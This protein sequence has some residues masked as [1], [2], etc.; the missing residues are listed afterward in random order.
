MLAAS[1][2]ALILQ[3][4]GTGRFFLPSK[5]LSVLSL[6]IPVVCT[7]DTDSELARA[8]QSGEFGI[9][10]PAADAAVLS[11]VL[12]T[13]AEDRGRLTALRQRTDWVQRFSGPTVLAEFELELLRICS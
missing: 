1:D 12:Q 4:P 2:V 8:V 10:V 7:A 5:L 3:A 9:T 13:L 11:D 6:G